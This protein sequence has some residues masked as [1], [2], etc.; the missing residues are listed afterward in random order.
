MTS[1]K[2]RISQFNR[3]FVHPFLD[4]RYLEVT[5]AL[6]GIW[7]RGRPARSVWWKCRSTFNGF[8]L[9]VLARTDFWGPSLISCPGK[10]WGQLDRWQFHSL[11]ALSDFWYDTVQGWGQDSVPKMGESESGQIT[12]EMRII[13]WNHAKIQQN[14][15]L[16]CSDFTKCR[17]NN[18]MQIVLI[19][20]CDRRLGRHR[21]PQLFN[22]MTYSVF[23]VAPD[24]RAFPDSLNFEQQLL[25]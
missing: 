5:F 7:R 20:P 17:L 21:L 24:K 13:W 23:M 16:H 15:Q 10:V 12:S 11:T 9:F 2:S 1:F 14:G 22:S 18:T 19:D 8:V 4:W 25:N 3:I 6:S